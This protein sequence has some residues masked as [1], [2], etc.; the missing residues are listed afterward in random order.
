M[1]PYGNG[2]EGRQ[3]SMGTQELLMI[4]RLYEKQSGKGASN[5]EVAGGLQAAVPRPPPTSSA[6]RKEACTLGLLSS[7]HTWTIASQAFVP[8][9]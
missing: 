7:G 5:S 3:D 2:L 4:N 9:S 1:R 8:R 6:V